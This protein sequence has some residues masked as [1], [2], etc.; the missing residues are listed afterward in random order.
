MRPYTALLCAFVSYGMSLSIRKRLDIPYPHTPSYCPPIYA[1]ICDTTGTLYENQ[2]LLWAANRIADPRF[3]AKKDDSGQI[4]CSFEPC[5][6]NYS[7]VC[8]SDGN[9]HFN[10]CLLETAGGIQD[11]RFIVRKGVNAPDTCVLEACGR[12]FA[13]ICSIDGKLFDNQCKLKMANTT[14]SQN[15]LVKSNSDG[16]FECASVELLPLPDA[17]YKEPEHLVCD[18]AGNWYY[19]LC[20]LSASGATFDPQ[21]YIIYDPIPTCIFPIE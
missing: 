5:S 11:S 14:A 3:K 18:K 15:H 1:P 2:C 6:K 16:T 10:P 7:P 19:N 9:L 20:Y 12:V 8:D 21:Y 4:T 13:P 17:C